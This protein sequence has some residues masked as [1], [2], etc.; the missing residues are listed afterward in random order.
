MPDF[1]MIAA[2]I[3][4]PTAIA[5]GWIAGELGHR[6]TGLPRISIYGI[7]GFVL[8]N[9]PFAY[10]LFSSND[11]LL[12]L[13]NIAFGLILFEFGYRVNLRW[14]LASPWIAAS[15]WTEAGLT[16]VGVYV[17]ATIL[18]TPALTA[19]LLASLAMSTSPAAV[20]RIVNE[21]RS[22]GAV[23]ERVLHLCALNC[24]ASVLVFHV[25][26]GISTLQSGSTVL[27][28]VGTSL[29][30]LILS[31]G[32]GAVFGIAVPGLLRSLAN[33][34]TDATLALGISVVV[35]VAATHALRLSPVLATLA[36]GLMTRQR[37]IVLSR[38]QRNFGTLGD[39]LTVLLF[40]FVA[41]TL[42]LQRMAAG[43]GLGLA[44]IVIRFATKTFGVTIFSHVS[45]TSVRK[46]FL[47]GLALTPISVFVILTL[48]QTRFLGIDL[49][50]Q[51][52]P[53]ATVTL[54]LEILGPI[55]TQQALRWAG[56]SR[57]TADRTE[58]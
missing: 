34:S 5:I 17:V 3:A 47:T 6:W 24:A 23:T 29:V 26:V 49:V 44:L 8:G 42:D 4:W 54:I 48:E 30:V 58:S 12:L 15:G 56:E 14:L 40:V 13:A 55:L 35:L 46:G 39:L 2:E 20:L 36:F 52:A 21:E 50:D 57:E 33:L 41:T 19:L 9:L 16:L 31:A 37:R 51:L 18:G 45:G 22:S 25:V 53:L 11:S 10:P 1:L 28:A 43:L 7:V 27:N 38:T 32:I